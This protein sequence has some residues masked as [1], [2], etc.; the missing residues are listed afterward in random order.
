LKPGM[1]TEVNIDVAEIPD[2]LLV[3]VQSVSDQAGKHCAYVRGKKGIERRD[4]EVGDNNQKFIEIRKGVAE[5]EEV[6][7]ESRARVALEAKATETQLSHKPKA[8][9]PQPAP[10]A[11]TP[12]TPAAPAKAETGAA[13]VQTREP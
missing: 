13:A 5:N 10:A 9:A 8:T 12:S 6:K 2:V 7:L 1:T 4:V 11:P 3:P